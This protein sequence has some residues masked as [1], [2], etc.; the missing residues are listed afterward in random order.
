MKHLILTFLVLTIGSA[1]A[2][3]RDSITLDDHYL[4]L[5]TAAAG[6]SWK[7]EQWIP[8]SFHAMGE[9]QLEVMVIHSVFTNGSEHDFIH[10]TTNGDSGMNSHCGMEMTPTLLDDPHC[11]QGG[12]TITFNKGI[13][14]G[15]ISMLL[16]STGSDDSRDSLVVMPFTCQK[17]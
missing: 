13:L 11:F 6:L 4:C 15:G 3:D 9:F 10:F 7:G 14:K 17:R 5:N 16:G 2:K 12:K 8:A 1:I